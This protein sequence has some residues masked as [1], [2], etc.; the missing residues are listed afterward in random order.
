VAAA[1][2]VV[3]VAPVQA[4]LLPEHPG[5]EQAHQVVVLL[6]RRVSLQPLVRRLALA[7]GEAVLRRRRCHLA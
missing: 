4:R 5:A 6:P 1:V 2:V 7:A 3:D